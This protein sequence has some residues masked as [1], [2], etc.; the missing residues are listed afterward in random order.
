MTGA[1]QLTRAVRQGFGAVTNG[2]LRRLEVASLLWN[3][4][5]QV[6]LVGLIVFAFR[7]GGAGLVAL[8][9]IGQTAPSVAALPVL[10]R[11]TASWRAERL[12]GALVA[13]RAVSIGGATLVLATGSPSWLV[14]L[15]AGVDALA[16]SLVR[17]TRSVL[18]PRLARSTAELVAS[19]V[20]I[21]TGR[22]A[23]GIVGPG[24]AAILLATHDVTA[25][26]AVGAGLFASAFAIS[27]GVRAAAPLPRPAGSSLPSTERWIDSLRP[28]RHAR[29]IVAVLVGQQLVRGMLPIVLVALAVELL[30]SGDEG[31]GIL[32]AAIGVGGLVGGG[33]TLALVRRVGLAG[34][35][36]AGVTLLGLGL[37]MPGLAP[38]AGPAV[39]A[40]GVSGLGKAVLEVS[41][42]TL[43]QRTVPVGLR[44]PVF[45]AL[46]TAA[47]VS[48]TT[49]AIAGA[50]LVQVVGPATTAIFA[51]ALPISIALV[52]WP[53]LRSADAVASVPE[54]ETSLLRAVPM[55]RPLGLCTME[56]LAAGVRMERVAPGTEVV[57]QGDNGDTFYVI[58]G[59]RLEVMVDGRPVRIIGAGE[60][61]GEIALIRD[62]ARTATV[63]AVEP[64]LLAVI[65]REQFLAAVMG[66]DESAA[67]AEEVIRGHLG[68]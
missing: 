52:V 41:G 5:E 19:N 50:L 31:Y 45:G 16:A 18:A 34:T 21:S 55:L 26:L 8:L 11:L 25:T 7:T 65:G 40:L 20:S 13:V 68:A 9:G 15:A 23:A 32:N 57:R 44:R 10:L 60:S 67:M 64:S 4:G 3:A 1:N 22:S 27:V 29:A 12:L 39:I 54:H 48:L 33:V 43:L 30:R 61:F 14:L 63:R 53:L 46:E 62:V 66:G 59:G 47:A 2:S 58:E 36:L 17:S 51:G 49:G 37:M 42:I 28:L 24:L 6:Y 56:E 38:I 35:F